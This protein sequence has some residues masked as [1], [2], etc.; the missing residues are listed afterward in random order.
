MKRQGQH[1]LDG[2]TTRRQ[3]DDQHKCPHATGHERQDP[4]QRRALRAWTLSTKEAAV[5][6]RAVP[7]VATASPSNVVVDRGQD[8]HARADDDDAKRSQGSAAAVHRASRT[9]YNRFRLA[10]QR[11][12]A[13]WPPTAAA[14]RPPHRAGERDKLFPRLTR[15]IRTY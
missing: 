11:E 8:V 9:D 4:L 3:Q 5:E 10:H 7:S 1:P 6:S 12:A 13:G 14:H 15:L 2:I